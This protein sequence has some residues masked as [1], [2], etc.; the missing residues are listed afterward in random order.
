V[1]IHGRHR[2]PNLQ[3][4]A[5]NAWAIRRPGTNGWLGCALSPRQPPL[6][7][8]GANAEPLS[9]RAPGL[10]A[11]LVCATMPVMALADRYRVL[12]ALARSGQ[13]LAPDELGLILDWPI[14]RVHAALRELV[15]MR[16]MPVGIEAD[17]AYFITLPGQRRLR[18]LRSRDGDEPNDAA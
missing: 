1:H 18:P 7:A 11:P 16:P 4:P 13:T 8:L 12:V 9:G 6:P 14:D 10:P 3:P 2:G 17:G 15:A 5:V